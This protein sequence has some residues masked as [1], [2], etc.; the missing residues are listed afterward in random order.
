MVRL[1]EAGRAQA[2]ETKRAADTRALGVR[3]LEFM[4]GESAPVST[5]RIRSGVS[6]RDSMITAA[7]R[8][9]VA[10]GDLKKNGTGKR[11]EPVNYSLPDSH[12]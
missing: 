3:I 9:L 10:D 8:N 11:S 4:E 5:E 6:G 2:F 7:L 1:D 12:L